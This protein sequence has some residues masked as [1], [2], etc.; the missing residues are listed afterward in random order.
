M[1][2]HYII[3][4]QRFIQKINR[5]HTSGNVLH[6]TKTTRRPWKKGWNLT[7]ANEGTDQSKLRACCEMITYTISNLQSSEQR[8][9]TPRKKLENSRKITSR[10]M[11]YFKKMKLVYNKIIYIKTF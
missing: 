11:M 10:E 5:T 2:Y 3:D 6:T 1:T 9:R 7:Y 8:N 4:Q